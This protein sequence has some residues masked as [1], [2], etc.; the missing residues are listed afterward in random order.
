M[1]VEMVLASTSNRGRGAISIVWAGSILVTWFVIANALDQGPFQQQTSRSLVRFGALLGSDFN[2][3][4]SWRL[5]ASQWLHVNFKHM[6]FNALVIAVVGFALERWI[7]GTVVLLAGIAGGALAQWATVHAYLNAY[8]S[9]ASQAYLVLCGM[10]LA[11][12]PFRKPRQ[13]LALVAA[14]GAVAIAAGLDLLVSDHR[15]IKV[16]HLVGL[17]FGLGAGIWFRELLRLQQKRRVPAENVAEKYH[18]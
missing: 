4:Q 17:V 2:P 10:A 18:P 12:F 14:V 13:L 5:I 8:I 9:G 3:S 16:G 11:I 1:S 7:R 15:A 6:V